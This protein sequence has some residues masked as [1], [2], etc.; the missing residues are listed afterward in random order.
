MR[1]PCFKREYSSIGNR[2]TDDEN[3]ES[4]REKNFLTVEGKFSFLKF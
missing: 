2:R 1:K 3:V 4:V